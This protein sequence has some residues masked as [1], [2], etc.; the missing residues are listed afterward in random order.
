MLHRRVQK[1][2]KDEAQT[3]RAVCVERRMHGSA[4]VVGNVPEGHALAAY[5]T[6]GAKYRYSLVATYIP[7]DALAVQMQRGDNEGES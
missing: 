6:P 3:W 5:P 2:R 4:G 1:A 7:V